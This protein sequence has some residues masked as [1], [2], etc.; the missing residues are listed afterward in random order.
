MLRTVQ[1]AAEISPHDGL[2]SGRPTAR[3]EGRSA[4][5]PLLAVSRY[6]REPPMTVTMPEAWAASDTP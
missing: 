1:E 2:N 5:A 6:E 3:V 4:S